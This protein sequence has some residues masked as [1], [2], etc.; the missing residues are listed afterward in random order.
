MPRTFRTLWRGPPGGGVG[1]FEK[2]RRVQKDTRGKRK[3]R[4]CN[5]ISLVIDEGHRKKKYVQNARALNRKQCYG[6]RV[7]GRG[8][9]RIRN[10]RIRNLN[11][12]ICCWK[13][14]QRK[15]GFEKIVGIG[16]GARYFDVG[17]RFPLS[18][19]KWRNRDFQPSQSPQLLLLFGRLLY[20]LRMETRLVNMEMWGNFALLSE[21]NHKSFGHT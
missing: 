17:M 20:S 11:I 15:Y 9:R 8:G 12:M 19:R 1:G 18:Q 2:K 16:R 10:P 7:L 5:R 3:E 14:L 13:R 6:I 4:W 21:T